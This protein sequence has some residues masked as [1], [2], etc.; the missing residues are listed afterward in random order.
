[1][2]RIST[3]L[4]AECQAPQKEKSSY[5]TPVLTPTLPKAEMMSKRMLK[6]EN[7]GAAPARFV[8]SMAQMRNKAKN[9]KHASE[10]NW[11]LRWVL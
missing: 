8:R 1:M 9:R 6:V 2:T 3:H 7:P 10:A 4:L 11:P 5:G